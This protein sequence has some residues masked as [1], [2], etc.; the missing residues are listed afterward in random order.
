MAIA[1][2]QQ[3][4]NTS[5]ATAGQTSFT[6]TATTFTAGNLLLA[7]VSWSLSGSGTP[8][9]G[10]PSGW[11]GG[12]SL[13]N[14]ATNG[15]AWVGYIPNCAGGSQSWTWTL[16][17]GGM[18]TLE[19]AWTIF[20]FSGAATTS[21]LDLAMVDAA[22]GSSASTSLSTG[23]ASGTTQAGDLII[24]LSG[25]QHGSAL[26]FTSSATS[27]P[28]SGWTVA[29]T[30]ESTGTSPYAGV[31]AQYQV[32]SGTVTNPAGVLTSSA[33]TSSENFLLT[34]TA[35]GGS[36]LAWTA[37]DSETNTDS[38]S[39]ALTPTD[40]DSETLSE[41]SSFAY[42]PVLPADTETTTDSLSSTLTPTFADSQVATDSAAETF[43]FSAGD[44][45]TGT[46]SHNG[47]L[48]PVFADTEAIAPDTWSVSAYVYTP[49]AD[50]QTVT[51]A[52]TETLTWTPAAD[53]ETVTDGW[54]ATLSG[55]LS[56]TATDSETTTDAVTWT[57]VWTLSP[58]DILTHTDGS[59]TTFI[60]GPPAD[61]ETVATGVWTVGA[62]TWVPPVDAQALTDT[63]SET[64][65]WLPAGDS[66]TLAP[67]SLSGALAWTPA[68]DSETVAADV[69]AVVLISTF[70]DVLAVT[71]SG[72]F[73][74]SWLPLADSE[75]NADAGTFT[76][77]SG[78]VTPTVATVA[79]VRNGVQAGQVRS[80]IQAG[81]VRG[82]TSTLQVR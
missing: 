69:Q 50:T 41:S 65:S 16:T 31:V 1:L 14:G 21:P 71:D 70:A 36:A 37:A 73:V 13:K 77:I 28:S 80:G 48:T 4:G 55:G 39:W 27:V 32:V 26:T 9:I 34:F 44:T 24:Q 20:E 51:E 5:G 62:Y 15:V 75:A 46:D 18:S 47:V 72:A 68:A 2:V 22:T 49:A 7:V 81:Q 78:L 12:T 66:E 42:V 43:T 63:A 74:L 52:L 60:Y 10:T 61:S 33:N 3:V 30:Y 23:A 53:S 17:T 40:S 6:S 56:W 8:S 29:T 79:Y 45:Q 59:A 25:F 76:L 64:L 57:E 67:D 38:A 35:A 82:G 54:T 11:S 19:W 58:A